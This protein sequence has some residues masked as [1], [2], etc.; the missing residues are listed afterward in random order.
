MGILKYFPFVF[1]FIEL[2]LHLE[3][4]AV[5]SKVDGITAV[6]LLIKNARYSIRNP[7][8]QNGGRFTAFSSDT[9]PI[10]RGN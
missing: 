7:A 10:L 2:F 5:S 8:M 3:R 9:V 1:R 4:L 6:S